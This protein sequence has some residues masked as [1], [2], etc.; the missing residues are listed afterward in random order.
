MTR[1]LAVLLVFAASVPGVGMF[2]QAPTGSERTPGAPL[3]RS[4]PA[5]DV[6]TALRMRGTI[7]KY[8]VPTRTLSLATANGIV[9]FRVALMA[10][11]RQHWQYIDVARLEALS[12]V[13]A[14]VRYTEAN[15]AKIVESVHLFGPSERTDR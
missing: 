6:A 1:Q 8:D 7:E 11:V 2:A 9:Q 13:R 12:G 4:V 15:G 14:A 5:A 3:T 10:H